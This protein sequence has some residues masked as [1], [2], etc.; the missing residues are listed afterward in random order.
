MRYICITSR[1]AIRRLDGIVREFWQMSDRQAA[2]SVRESPRKAGKVLACAN[3][4]CTAKKILKNS[5]AE[6]KF[7]SVK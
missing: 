6:Y 3:V 1:A 2:R 7:I 4:D 5:F